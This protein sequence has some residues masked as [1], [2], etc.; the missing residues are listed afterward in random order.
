MVEKSIISIMLVRRLSVCA[1]IEFINVSVMV[2]LLYLASKALSFIKSIR[3]T[4][5]SHK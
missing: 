5:N 2:A 3:L 4:L 1:F